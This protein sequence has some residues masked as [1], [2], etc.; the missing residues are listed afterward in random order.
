MAIVGLYSEVVALGFSFLGI[1]IA[2]ACLLTGQ[3]WMA[4]AAGKQNV[5]MGIVALLV[6]IVGLVLA[7][8]HRGSGL[9]GAVMYV[10]C[11]LP[12]LLVGAFLGTFKGM[13]TSEGRAQARTA[14]FDQSLPQ[15]ESMIRRTE[16]VVAADAPVETANF[17]YIVVGQTKMPTVQEFDALLAVYAHYVKGSFAVD[18]Q[19]KTVT[20]EYRGPNRAK[21]QFQLLLYNRMQV[22]LMDSE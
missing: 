1:A 17:R 14:N 6:P 11:L 21:T 7:A 4:V 2:V 12:M 10:S 19:A 16:Q 13:Y 3:V 20:F 15:F 18:P 22:M 9:R 5:A 8:K